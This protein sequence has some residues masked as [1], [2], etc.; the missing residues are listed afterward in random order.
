MA[1]QIV[2][3]SIEVGNV[4]ESVEISEAWE[5][6]LEIVPTSHWVESGSLL[7][8]VEIQGANAPNVFSS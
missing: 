2:S 5:S 3:V 6:P 8:R 1:D 7:R 4:P